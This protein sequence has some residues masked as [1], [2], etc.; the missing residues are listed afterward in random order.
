MGY[1]VPSSIAEIA[2]KYGREGEGM[3][4]W[5]NLPLQQK[6]RLRE[7]WTV[8]LRLFPGMPAYAARVVAERAVWE[9]WD[10]RDNRA[11][12]E[13]VVS[14]IRHE[15]TIYEFRLESAGQSQGKGSAANSDEQQDGDSVR[16]WMRS[17]LEILEIVKPRIREVTKSWL[18]QDTSATEL[19]LFW[20]RHG[21]LDSADS[22]KEGFRQEDVLL[23]KTSLMD[24]GGGETIAN[25]VS[26]AGARL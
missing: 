22:G 17:K 9:R 14:H 20:R 1:I 21:L 8:S 26:N 24:Y 2:R 18:P 12:E 23:T 11:M 5:V 19:V 16:Q 4:A 3:A 10:E 6:N 15:W 13:R 25:L 7:A